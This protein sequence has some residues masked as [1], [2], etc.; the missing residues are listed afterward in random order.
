MIRLV[1]LLLLITVRT[2]S[3]SIDIEYAKSI[4]ADSMHTYLYVLASDSLEGRE[5]GKPGQKK[6]AKFLAGKYK[7]WNIPVQF[8]KHSLSIRANSGKNLD[9]NNQY[10]VYY[11]NFFY[12]GPQR[13][14]LFV[15]D[16]VLIA[17]FG[18]SQPSYDDFAGKKVVG[19]NLVVRWAKPEWKKK[20]K[21]N[22][23][24]PL[25]SK[26]LYQFITDL[27]QKD[28]KMFPLSSIFF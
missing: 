22:K 20:F 24:Q 2:F 4:S 14:S 1:S 13:D 28:N 7:E 27:K 26:S 10:F 21:K 16:K 23:T 25:Q 5:T 9:I 18:I 19:E 17:G 8:Q 11:S 12:V 3:Q 15:F 6:A